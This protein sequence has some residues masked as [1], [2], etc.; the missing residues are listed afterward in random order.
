MAGVME[1]LYGRF[2]LCHVP[3]GPLRVLL[4]LPDLKSPTAAL[5]WWRLSSGES[6]DA[7]SHLRALVLCCTGAGTTWGIATSSLQNR[8]LVQCQLLRFASDKT[9]LVA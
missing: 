6:V 9:S 4:L 3:S 1:K 8:L 7:Y 2:C 5:V